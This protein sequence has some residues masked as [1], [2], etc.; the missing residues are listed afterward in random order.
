MDKHRILKR[1]LEMKMSGK[2]PK[3]SPHTHTQWLDQI[4]RE[5]ERRGLSWEKVEEMLERTN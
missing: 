3:G 2:I 4:K 5:T 1:V